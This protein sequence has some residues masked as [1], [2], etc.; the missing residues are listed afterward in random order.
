MISIVKMIMEA[1]L[2]R[3]DKESFTDKM[4]PSYQQFQDKWKQK[5][6]ETVKT[7]KART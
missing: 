1:G 5:G 6:E 3:G 4:K 2:V 7:A